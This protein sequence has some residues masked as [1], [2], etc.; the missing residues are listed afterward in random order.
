MK[1]TWDCIRGGN[2]ELDTYIIIHHADTLSRSS[3]TRIWRR[4]QTQSTKSHLRPNCL[5]LITL[6]KLYSKHCTM[7]RYPSPQVSKKQ[8]LMVLK[9]LGIEG[10][11]AR[12]FLPPLCRRRLRASL[13]EEASPPFQKS[14]SSSFSQK[15]NSCSVILFMFLIFVV[16]K[17]DMFLW[18]PQISFR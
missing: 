7:C 6:P 11:Q 8:L 15:D 10:C 14:T 4:H 2:L 1:S 3:C 12:K 5:S 13:L 18:R 9:Q 17:H 16:V